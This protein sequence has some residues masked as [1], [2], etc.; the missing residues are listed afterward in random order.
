MSIFG[1]LKQSK[2]TDTQSFYMSTGLILARQGTI[3]ERP[4]VALHGG[5]L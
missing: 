5:Q 3:L 4:V 1:L 2:Q